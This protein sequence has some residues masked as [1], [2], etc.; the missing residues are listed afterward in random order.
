MVGE[1]VGILDYL[2]WLGEGAEEGVVSRYHEVAG[3]EEVE[4]EG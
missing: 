2:A 3:E 1:G 4:W